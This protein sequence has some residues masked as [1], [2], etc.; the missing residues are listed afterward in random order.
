VFLSKDFLGWDDDEYQVV[1]YEGPDVKTL[2]LIALLCVVLGSAI[3]FFLAM[4]YNKKFNRKVR[5]SKFFRRVNSSTNSLVR[6][7]FALPQIDNIDELERLV[8]M[9]DEGDENAPQF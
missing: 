8:R 5:E 3:G 9:Q 2:V 7:S 1:I 6:K 4:H